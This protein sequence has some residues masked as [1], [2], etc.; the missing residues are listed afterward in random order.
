MQNKLVGYVGVISLW[1]TMMFMNIADWLQL[2]AGEATFARGVLAVVVVLVVTGF[3]LERPTWATLQLTIAFVVATLC[4]F[5]GA[6]AWGTTYTVVFLDFAFLV[7][8]LLDLR[9]RR[10]H[11]SVPKVLAL[12]L[13][14]LG[15]TLTLRVFAE[16]TPF[17][18]VG[19]LWS[20]GALL[21][22]GGYILVSSAVSTQG[23]S[24]SNGPWTQIFFV[25]LGLVIGGGAMWGIEG[26]HLSSVALEITWP[27]IFLLLLF[28]AMTG[29]LNLAAFFFLVA[30]N[31]SGTEIGILVLGVTPSV[32]FAS[33]FIGKELSADQWGGVILT[34]I[35]L[36]W[37][38][39]QS[40]KKTI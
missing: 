2:S 28:S 5:E 20:L 12:L 25:G 26:Y 9:L 13:A 16:D 39:W 18:V 29:L 23:D 34:M 38:A 8:L 37:Y 31:L 27:E 30:K 24:R 6:A 11:M 35:A 15:T 14:L 1:I 33:A 19:L 36:G 4:I 10:V 21:T 17:S 40:R 3:R 32:A 22:N 7:P